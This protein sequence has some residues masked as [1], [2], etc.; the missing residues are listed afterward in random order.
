MCRNYTVQSLPQ[1]AFSYRLATDVLKEMMEGSE[2]V[3]LACKLR[4]FNEGDTGLPPPSRRANR[5]R[6]GGSKGGR[7]AAR[8]GS[9]S[10][11]GSLTQTH[12]RARVASSSSSGQR[13]VVVPAVS[14][15]S[16]QPRSSQGS[17]A[18][19]PARSYGVTY[20]GS[21]RL[22]VDDD[23]SARTAVTM[24][25][26][27]QG[28]S[29]AITLKVSS[30]GAEIVEK[31]KTAGLLCRTK[32]IAYVSLPVPPRPS[33]GVARS[34][35]TSDSSKPLPCSYVAALRMSEDTDYFCIA[36]LGEKPVCHVFAAAT[37]VL[38]S[39]EQHIAVVVVGDVGSGHTSPTSGG[40]SFEAQMSAAMSRSMA[41]TGPSG[42]GELSEEQQL[43]LALKE[44]MQSSQ[45]MTQSLTEDEQIEIALRESERQPAR[46]ATL[47]FDKSNPFAGGTDDV[48]LA[49]SLEMDGDG[50]AAW[51]A[52]LGRGSVSGTPSSDDPRGTPTAIATN[53]WQAAG[54]LAAAADTLRV[55]QSESA[56]S[57]DPHADAEYAA[58]LASIELKVE[59]DTGVSLNQLRG[60]VIASSVGAALP[61]SAHQAGAGGHP[62]STGNPFDHFEA[63]P[64]AGFTPATA[65]LDDDDDLLYG[66]ADSW[67]A[68]TP[69][70]GSEGEEDD[71]DDDEVFGETAPV[72]V[73]ESYFAEQQDVDLGDLYVD[74][75]PEDVV[76]VPVADLAYVPRS[77]PA[78]EGAYSNAGPATAT[79][80]SSVGASR[81]RSDTGATV[82]SYVYEGSDDED[83]NMS[84]PGSY[85]VDSAAPAS[86]GYPIPQ[87]PFLQ[88]SGMSAAAES[89]DIGIDGDVAAWLQNHSDVVPN[90]HFDTLDVDVV[91]HAGA[92]PRTVADPFH[93]NPFAAPTSQRT[94]TSVSPY[95]PQEEVFGEPDSTNPSV[96]DT[97][98]EDEDDL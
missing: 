95:T 86:G 59:K 53:K 1:Y 49:G 45:N 34:V 50:V 74:S 65:A 80:A 47:P 83:F 61:P 85:S 64:A 97:L 63:T 27:R 89:D 10:K 25:I 75:D 67:D 16:G 24:V 21:Q 54:A 69:D 60:R 44:S 43:E 11:A 42:L 4:P 73:G 81:E 8:Q 58:L 46:R 5:T 82:T 79:T 14:S 91:A 62:R 17:S 29:R 6:N 23:E 72:A 19:M 37:A 32:Q 87:A 28:K 13:T 31:G 2:R 55:L 30:N 39:I 71:D 52:A 12:T 88:S 18:H 33:P 48:S 3:S 84:A 20:V 90:A 9:K 96:E 35:L 41:E 93:A 98:Y 66:G 57:E 7:G 38:E 78:H 94:S 15:P 77:E 26:S 68:E 92:M 40:A 70:A 36:L 22:V 56:H 76:A 51:Q